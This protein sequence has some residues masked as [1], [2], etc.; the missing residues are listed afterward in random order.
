MF[1]FAIVKERDRVVEGE[2]E[3]EKKTKEGIIGRERE[4]EKIQKEIVIY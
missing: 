4:K 3:I 2:R 1:T